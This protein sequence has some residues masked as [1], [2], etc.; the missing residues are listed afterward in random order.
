MNYKLLIII[1][2]LI[3]GVAQAGKGGAVAGGLLGGYLLGSAVTSASQPR[4]TE[5]VYVNNTPSR[6]RY[7][8]YEDREYEL[9]CRERRLRERER[10]LERKRTMT[11]RYEKDEDL[12][13][14]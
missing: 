9:R 12:D 4:R 1:L 11:S 13:E 14:F 3:P 7:D 6:A 8:D 2:L 5:V 10:A